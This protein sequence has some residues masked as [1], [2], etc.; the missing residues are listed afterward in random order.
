M[1]YKT[2]DE[3]VC[4]LKR[5]YKGRVYEVNTEVL[6]PGYNRK[7]GDIAKW[8]DSVC[9]FIYKCD[10]RNLEKPIHFSYIKFATKKDGTVVGIVG[11]KS[12]FTSRYT[13]DVCFYDL[14]GKK[15]SSKPTAVTMKAEGLK[16]YTESIVIFK[17][18][19]DDN[20]LEAFSNE[21]DL[22][23]LFLLKD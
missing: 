15:Q 23:R 4:E 16:W 12:S 3:I 20:R 5:D 2:K 19:N 13:S 14:N 11:G 8:A 7:R 18:L 22:Q 6:D 21:A 17:N 10:R 1:E 9:R